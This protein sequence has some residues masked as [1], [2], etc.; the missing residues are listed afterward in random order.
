[1]RKYKSLWDFLNK[2]PK[3]LWSLVII[4]GMCLIMIPVFIQD[5]GQTEVF[6]R[7]FFFIFMGLIMFL[8]WYRVWKLY[9]LNK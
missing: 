9:K 2:T 7:W 1:M 8:G 6:W 3:N 5:M 4:W